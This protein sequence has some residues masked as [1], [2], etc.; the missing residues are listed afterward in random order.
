MFHQL[1]IFDFEDIAHVND[2]FVMDAIAKASNVD[3]ALAIVNASTEMKSKLFGNM[4]GRRANINREE[5]LIGS[6]TYT[7]RGGE[8][9]QKR[10][11]E[12]VNRRIIDDL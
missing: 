12:L 10:I 6:G 5:M 7:P 4:P 3:L 2:R 1:P 8:L 11:L 9:A